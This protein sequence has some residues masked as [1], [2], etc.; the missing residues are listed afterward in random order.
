MAATFAPTRYTVIVEFDTE[1]YWHLHTV[2]YKPIIPKHIFQDIGLEGWNLWNP[3]PPD[4]AMVTSGPFNV[5]DYVMGEYIELTYN[6][7]YLFI[8]WN[9]NEPRPEQIP[10]TTTGNPAPPGILPFVP[11]T[12]S[13]LDFAITI[14]SIIVIAVVLIKWKKDRSDGNY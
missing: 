1:S 4:D 2:S 14:P 9:P 12:I 13:P 5:S 8:S 11:P 10:I 7:N 6:P 3:I